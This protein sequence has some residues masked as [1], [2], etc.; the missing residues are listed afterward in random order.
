MRDSGVG[1]AFHFGR[2]TASARKLQRDNTGS[3]RQRKKM[4]STVRA[5]S[6]SKKYAIQKSAFSILIAAAI[7]SSSSGCGGGGGGGGT[8]AQDAQGPSVTFSSPDPSGK[9]TFPAN[10]ESLPNKI[11]INYSD[12]SGIQTS[13]FQASFAFQGADF[14]M[15]SLF[16]KGE[17]SATT[18]S[19]VSPLYWT[20]ISV[21]DTTTL[22]PAGTINVYGVSSA[23]TGRFNLMDTDSENNTLIIAA[24][25][26]NRLI[27]TN[28]DGSGTIR[29][30]SL[31]AKPTIV[32]VC[33]AQNKVYVA[34]DAKK[35]LAVYNI[36]TGAQGTPVTLDYVPFSMV[37]NKITS[38]IYAIFEN[39]NDLSIVNCSSGTVQH[40]PLQNMPQRIVTDGGVGGKLFIA[41]GVGATNR[42]V[43][44]YSGGIETKLFSL[45]KFPEAISY[46]GTTDRL[47]LAFFG[48]DTASVYNAGTGQLI[49]N[50]TVG[51]QPFSLDTDTGSGKS[52]CLNKEN[53]SV[54]VISG[55]NPSVIKT[56][57]LEANPVGVVSDSESGKLFVFQNIWEITSSKQGTISVSVKDT[58]GNTGDKTLKITVTP[59]STDEPDNPP[60]NLQ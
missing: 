3:S 49:R 26:R 42:G 13:T 60:A 28:T 43:Y 35:N 15:S 7:L 10:P 54:S 17:R 30:I 55:A 58:V 34:R 21:Y 29:E 1:L 41:G 40:V 5:I 52:F 27:F 19:D 16:T 44:Q 50:I 47:F 18:G 46:D 22:A 32:R 2:S 9:L 51:G 25:S 24:T 11:S 33:P 12:T 45:D 38:K 59:V 48:S 57:G 8:P 53:D 6:N 4:K 23:S 14:D 31:D 56:L 20:V 39:S 37:V 36:S